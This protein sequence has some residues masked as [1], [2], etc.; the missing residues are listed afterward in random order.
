M[1]E[2]KI[3]DN[4]ISV[5]STTTRVK[6]RS[7]KKTHHVRDQTKI[8]KHILTVLQLI[9]APCVFLYWL[10]LLLRFLLAF[11]TLT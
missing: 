5:V 9:G 7:W 10:K 6:R 1:T 4:I 2:S 8:C 3:S 11:I